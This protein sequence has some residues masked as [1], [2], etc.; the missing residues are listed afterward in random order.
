M[1]PIIFNS[2]DLLGTIF[3]SCNI[4]LNYAFPNAY[5]TWWTNLWGL[6][7]TATT[8]HSIIDLFIF[9][10]KNDTLKFLLVEIL[11]PL[12][13]C[14]IGFNMLKLKDLFYDLKVR[15]F[16]SSLKES[17]LVWDM[18]QLKSKS[19]WMINRKL[20]CFFPPSRQKGK[21]IIIII[22]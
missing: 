7:L 18:H 20:L 9:C 3:K 12:I 15:K 4:I 16:F 14:L 8:K 10:K 21:I 17:K 5:L 1:A 11:E 2:D 22:V 19:F 6:R 13:H